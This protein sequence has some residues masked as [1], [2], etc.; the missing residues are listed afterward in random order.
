MRRA[1]LAARAV[2]YALLAAAALAATWSLWRA[3]GLPYNVDIS[4][5]FPLTT[6]AYEARFWPLWNE[7]GGMA[8]LQFLPALLF[9]LPLLLLG[10]LFGWDMA[11]HVKLRITLGF[12]LAGWGLYALARRYLAKHAQGRLAPWLVAAIPLAPALFFMFNPWSVHRV[13]QHFLWM[14]YVLAPFLI[15][16]FERLAESPTWRRALVFALVAAVA[17]TDP[18]NPPY[19]AL[20][21]APLVV[22]RV[23][24]ALRRSKRDAGRLAGMMGLAAG[25]Y[26]LLGAFWILPYA[27]SALRNPAMGPTYVMSDEMLGVLSRHATLPDVLRLLHNYNPRAALGPDVPGAAALWSAAGFGLA[28]LAFAAPLLARRSVA[29]L[30]AGLAAAC[31]VLGMGATPPVGG[32][33]RW[34]LFGAPWGEG[35]SWLFRDP[36][37]WGGFQALAYAVLLTF[38]LGELAILATR[39]PQ[40]ASH[41]AESAIPSVALAC[42]ALFVLPG[43]AGYMGEVYA[44][45][46]V[47]SEYAQANAQLAAMPAAASVVWMPRTLGTTTWG[48]DRTLEYFDATSSARAALGPFRPHTSTYFRFLEDAAKDGADLPPLLA[49]AGLDAVV[50]HNDRDPTRDARKAELLEQ[51]G[52]VEGARVGSTPTRWVDQSSF[53]P[54]DTPAARRPVDATR[55]LAQTF[56]PTAPTPVE[57]TLRARPVGEPGPL[58][59]A[60]LD[61]NGTAVA[62]RYATGAGPEVA[63]P[64]RGVALDPGATYTLRLAAANAANG[65]RWD[66]S[67]YTVDTY[68]EGALLDAPG[69][70]AFELV[71]QERGFVTLYES[72]QDA[73]RVRATSGAVASPGGLQM[74]RAL[75]TLPDGAPLRDDAVV[76]TATS[77]AARRAFADES[78]WRWVGGLND[79]SWEGVVPFLPKDVFAAP[80]KATTRADHEQAWARGTEDFTYYQWGWSSALADLKQESWDFDGDRG[81]AYTTSTAPL[82]VPVPHDGTLLARVYRHPDGGA[83]RVEAVVDGAPVPLATLDARA[84]AAGFAWVGV[85]E[86]PAGAS[87]VRLVGDGSFAAVN[88]LAAVPAD[89]L[90]SAQT[91]SAARFDGTPATLL[92]NAETIPG[93]GAK[94]VAFPGVGRFVDVNRTTDVATS[95]PASG[96]YAVWVRLAAGDPAPNL[97]LDGADL[98]P[99]A[100]AAGCDGAAP[101]FATSPA[102]LDAGPHALRFEIP[103][104]ATARVDALALTSEPAGLLGGAAPLAIQWQRVDATRYEATLDATGPV[105]VVL[106]TPHD[107]GWVARVEGADGVVRSVPA[108][109]VANAFRLDL[110]GPSRVTLA[111]EPQAWAQNGAWVSGVALVVALAAFVLPFVARGLARPRRIRHEELP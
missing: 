49:R 34:L 74:L 60:L 31:V 43:L 104:G 97:T 19:F 20:L 95:V 24:Q 61:A 12:V 52:L 70:L 73:P 50:F 4:G 94:P 28:A 25:A 40:R 55:S 110:H 78:G 63:V 37:R 85:G 53:A 57:L 33:Y 100:C 81:F 23:A 107:A 6:D 45:V 69:D 82:V 29:W 47:P 39:L 59:V 92:A 51:G 106:A 48:G 15:L 96:A 41:A 99:L 26:L 2:P 90:A 102:H 36:Y 71:A 109:G 91:A 44:P 80:F 111:Y 42:A 13:F 56:V 54:A 75:A 16:A 67:T 11:T 66:V 9:E 22:L 87:A 38:A 72:P 68:V 17:T 30:Y 62:T 88:L 101:W 86:L 10:R 32:F 83:L 64:L 27:V 105:E 93:F 1:D 3:P 108:D 35:L 79:S 103:A 77:E 46:E 89:V 65:S 8:T 14:G 5:F 7:H 18:H 58:E 98:G 21:L 76:F 84:P